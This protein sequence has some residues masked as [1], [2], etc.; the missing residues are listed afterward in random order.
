MDWIEKSDS[1][2]QGQVAQVVPALVSDPAAVGLVAD[3]VSGLAA[4]RADFNTKLAA[5]LAAKAALANAV[6]EKDASR[7]TLQNTLRGLAKRIQADP[8]VTDDAR[9]AAGIPVP[10]RVRST[11]APITPSQL[12]A[13]EDGSSAALVSWNS[14]GNTSGIR[15]VVEKRVGNAG[16]WSLVDVVSATK[17]HVVGLTPGIRVD[18]RVKAR[19]GAVDSDPSSVS[20]VNA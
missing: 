9:R 10:D 16:E 13:V 15:Y 20:S 11:N 12:V 18:F 14:N 7:A 17:K 2:F 19:R 6:A 5:A 4:L 3:D 8:T 1:G